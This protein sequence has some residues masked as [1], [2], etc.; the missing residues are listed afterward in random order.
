[1]S[2]RNL[3]LNKSYDSD[4]CDI[5]NDFYIPALKESTT[6][7]RLSG[8]FCSTSLA[9][10]A[11]GIAQF[12]NN[13][14]K[15]KIIVSARLNR[16]D[17]KAIEEAKSNPEKVIENVMLRDISNIDS[18]FIRDH[19]RALG[20]MVANKKLEIRVA[21]FKDND[22]KLLD[23][24]T[25]RKTGMFHP[26]VGVL[27]D[28]E[29]NKI[30]FSGS[31][32]ETANAWI[33]NI[34]EFKVFRSWEEPEKE[35]LETD[36]HRFKRFW[37]G[38]GEKIRVIDVPLAVKKKLIDISPKRIEQLDL[39]KWYK[40]CSNE[41]KKSGI[42]LFDY[43]KKAVV[44]WVNN[45]NLGI[46]EMATGT[47]KTYTALGCLKKLSQKIDRLLVII[48]SPTAH[49]VKQWQRNITKF[50]IDFDTI[51][52]DS[53]N[54]RWKNEVADSIMDLKLG[55]KKNLIVLTTHDTFPSTD[56]MDIISKKPKNVDTLLI[57]DEVHGIGSPERKKGLVDLYK[58]RLGLSA[59]P[60]RWFDY[61]GTDK[62]FE[63][64]GGTVYEFPLEKAIK[65]INPATGKTFLTPYNYKPAFIEL[66]EHELLDYKNETRK[67]RRLYHQSKNN[68][69]K[70]ELYNLICIKR[71]KIVKNAVNKYE[72]FRQIIDEM[73]DIK[74]C[75]VYCSPGQIDTVKEILDEKRIIWHEFTQAEDTS[76]SDKYNGISEREHILNE[77][78][79]GTYNILVSMKI[80]D[81]GVDVPQAKI[82][83]I[84]ASDG[85]PR[86]YVQR[87]GR[88]LRHHEGKK[89]ATIYDVLVIPDTTAL[90]DQD[91]KSIE[92]KILQ[93]E[94]LRYKEF[95]NIA[96]NSL[97]C[98]RIIDK[99]EEKYNITLLG[100]EDE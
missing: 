33:N 81:E 96:K 27:E 40:K 6:Y 9:V 89:I 49:L 69:D 16:E 22:G 61:K 78:A 95:S 25:I 74:H 66:T 48:P 72:K 68:K 64:F 77:F 11:K 18:D 80:L 24:E 87:R 44:K 30:S 59:T 37:Y 19:V 42:N 39:T 1:M 99:I 65:E 75:L 97:E 90:N 76:P 71:Q 5:L 93:K 2:L 83:I 34:E 86:Q 51:I 26:K 57:V 54:S 7:Y 43:Q 47:G 52:A 23:D 4:S 29:G 58:Y 82:A 17:V 3:D 94:I 63:Y 60:K 38:Y 12:I 15:M 10:A 62:I 41:K 98:L 32:N 14:G 92:L 79:N 73:K 36:L 55:S 70:E 31:E 45:N 8:F 91:F 21:V 13:G 50:D 46:F 67:I 85:N 53:S 84:L 56:F 28:S 100:V 20:W 35:Y 88:I